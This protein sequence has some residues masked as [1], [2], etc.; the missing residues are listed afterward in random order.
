MSNV[1]IVIS[2]ASI[3]DAAEIARVFRQSF[4]AALPF[5]PELHTPEEDLQYFSEKVLPN[6]EVYVGRDADQR[7]VGFIAFDDEW[8]NHLYLLPDKLRQGIGEKLLKKAQVNRARLQLWAFQKNLRARQFYEKH[9]F[10]IVRFTDGA[11]NE[12][13]EPDVLM[14]WISR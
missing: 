7:I 10:V 14:E 1:A 3:E 2:K 6:N 4:R 11:D 5:L 9:G 13:R 8:V 12:E